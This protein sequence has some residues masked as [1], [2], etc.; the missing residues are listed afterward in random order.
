[1][2]RLIPLFFPVWNFTRCADPYMEAIRHIR[3]ACAH[4]PEREAAR[5]GSVF[6]QVHNELSTVCPRQPSPAELRE[7]VE[8]IRPRQ[9]VCHG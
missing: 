3:R 4:D 6:D 8:Q 5:V 9:A 2:S 1:M 7:A